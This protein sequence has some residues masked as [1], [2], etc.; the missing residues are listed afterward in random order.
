MLFATYRILHYNSLQK[1][2]SVER[3]HAGCP[4]RLNTPLAQ[5]VKQHSESRQGNNNNMGQ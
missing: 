3:G 5:C 1:I 4:S 2:A